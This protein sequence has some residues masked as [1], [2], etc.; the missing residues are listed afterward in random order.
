MARR[1]FFVGGLH[2][3]RAELAGDEARHLTRV[4]RVE[5]GQF[6]EIS[7]NEQVYLAEVVEARKDRVVFE[8]RQEVAPRRLPLR[9][10][11]LVSLIKFERLEWILEKGTELGVERF[12]VVNA[13]RSEKGL[14]AAAAKR[15]QRWEKI[16]RE[17]SQQSRR[18]HLPL[19]EGPVS[20]AEALR[21][22]GALRLLLEE[23]AEAAAPILRVLPPKRSPNDAAGVLCGPEGGWTCEERRQAEQSGWRAISLG[24]QILRTETAVI[25][26]TSVLMSAWG[27]EVRISAG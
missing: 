1:R 21:W 25:A 22:Q 24:P 19:V 7:D 3:Q 11:L 6:Y 5:K 12:V 27:E 2:R 9:L 23:E 16:V 20:F 15:V 13:A 8:A 14:A 17:S 4:L 18:D 10:T 26:A